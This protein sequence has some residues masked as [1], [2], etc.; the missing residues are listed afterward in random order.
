MSARNVT[1]EIFEPYFFELLGLWENFDHRGFLY[2]HELAL[3]PNQIDTTSGWKGWPLSGLIDRRINP[4]Y[5]SP[6]VGST[7]RLR[8]AHAIPPPPHSASPIPHANRILRSH[9]APSIS[10]SLSLSLHFPPSPLFCYFMSA[11]HDGAH[12]FLK[13]NRTRSA[14]ASRLKHRVGQPD[15]LLLCGFDLVLFLSIGIDDLTW[16]EPGF[17]LHWTRFFWLWM[18]LK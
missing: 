18:L 15:L 8:C 10:L 6:T 14:A 11:S 7:V 17:R 3:K 4:T 9:L 2:E 1:Q 12:A 13:L 16:I 5:L